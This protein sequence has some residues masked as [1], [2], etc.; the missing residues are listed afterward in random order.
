M[1]DDDQTVEAEND[2]SSPTGDPDLASLSTHENE[3]GDDDFESA[4]TIE[5]D[6]LE[7]FGS[8]E[9]GGDEFVLGASAKLDLQ[10]KI[11]AMI[12]ASPKCLKTSDLCGLL[13]DECVQ[14]S[15]IQAAVN[16]A[17]AEHRERGSGFRL[18]YVRGHG[19]QFRTVAAAAPYMERLFSQRPRPISRSALET[20]S[21]IAYRQPVTRAEIEFIRG[22]DAGSIMKGLL[23][24]D[25][26]KC[27]G[28][29]EDAGRP[30]LFGTTDEFLNVFRLANL[31]ELPPLS[32][33]QP[34]S[35]IMQKAMERLNM[36]GSEEEVDERDF[37]GDSAMADPEVSAGI[38]VE[39]GREVDPDVLGE[40]EGLESSQD[41]A[42]EKSDSDESMDEF[43]TY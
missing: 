18:E 31:S 2:D 12:F 37:V 20:L 21:I 14:M 28:R 32:S 13:Q 7:A 30:M 35:E 10:A 11:E 8:A 3:A 1:I 40:V 15:E 42:I 26:I 43:G 39:E 4:A 6:D 19:Y 23:E 17:V 41:L 36:I 29:K 5:L 34:P 33:F 9:T 38:A 25:L 22:V 27:V 16:C 24:R